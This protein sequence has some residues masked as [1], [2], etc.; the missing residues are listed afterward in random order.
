MLESV[1]VSKVIPC[2]DCERDPPSEKKSLN[3]ACPTVRLPVW[4]ATPESGDINYFS[5]RVQTTFRRENSQLNNAKGWR[6]L[7]SNVWKMSKI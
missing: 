7:I 4:P 2:L 1:G 5:F 3:A 6:N